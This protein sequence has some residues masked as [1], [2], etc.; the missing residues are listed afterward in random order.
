MVYSTSI[1]GMKASPSLMQMLK[2]QQVVLTDFFTL[3]YCERGK[4]R[5]VLSFF[6]ENPRDQSTVSETP[7]MV[8]GEACFSSLFSV[9]EM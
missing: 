3:D 5:V 1:H 4:F 7:R 2:I 6:V 8:R 9:C